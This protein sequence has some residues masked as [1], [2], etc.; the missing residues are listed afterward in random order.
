MDGLDRLTLIQLQI[1]RAFRAVFIDGIV[2]NLDGRCANPYDNAAPSERQH[3]AQ[4]Q[5]AVFGKIIGAEVAAR[6]NVVHH[7]LPP[8]IPRHK[9]AIAKFEAKR[10][11]IR[12]YRKLYATQQVGVIADIKQN[13]A[14]WDGRT[15]SRLADPKGGSIWQLDVSSGDYRLLLCVHG[16]AARLLDIV[17]KQNEKAQYARIQRYKRE[18]R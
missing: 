5:L 3:Y 2:A 14:D 18:C 12:A 7:D 16:N 11:Y 1:D 17:T 10:N 8:A 9:I 15:N 4:R 13:I 6:Q